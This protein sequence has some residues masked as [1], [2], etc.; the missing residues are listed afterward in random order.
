MFCIKISFLEPEP[1]GAELFWVE[2]E[3]IF[4]TWSLGR[5]L[6]KISEAGDEEKWLGFATLAR[7]NKSLFSNLTH[8]ALNSYF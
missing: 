4:F 2:P 1:G 5:S 6:K 3:P 8:C 7:A